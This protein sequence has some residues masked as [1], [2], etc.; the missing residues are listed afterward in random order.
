MMFLAE[1]VAKIPLFVYNTVPNWQNF[2]F[3][4][5]WDCIFMPVLLLLSYCVLYV[6]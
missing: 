4:L 6:L 5:S 2:D 1:F 3:L